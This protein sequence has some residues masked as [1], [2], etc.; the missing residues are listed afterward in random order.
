MTGVQGD[1]IRL[2]L[3]EHV[4]ISNAVELHGKLRDTL[5][6]DRH[7]TIDAGELKHIDTA[8]MQLLYC[9]VQDAIACGSK[10][11]WHQ[12]SQH[13]IYTASLLGLQDGLGLPD[14]ACGDS[15]QHQDR[16]NTG[17]ET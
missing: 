15:D 4:D 17:E 6:A 10:V 5:G 8:I 7:I 12:P 11:S 16:M 13:L 2:R 14:G 3:D 1:H 9:F